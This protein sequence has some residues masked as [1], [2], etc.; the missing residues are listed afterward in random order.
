MARSRGAAAA[1]APDRG[2]GMAGLTIN[3]AR[4]PSGETPVQGVPLEPYVLVRRSDNSSCNAEEVPE[5]G[6]GDARFS[7]RFRWYRSVV[8]RGGAVCFFH[9][10]RGRGGIARSA[11]RARGLETLSARAPGAGPR[12]DNPVH[13]VPAQQGRDAQELHVLDRLPA[14]ALGGAQGAARK[15]CAA[16]PRVW[17]CCRLPAS[18]PVAVPAAGARLSSWGARAQLAMARC[19]RTRT[20]SPPTPASRP[21]TPSATAARPG[22]RWVAQGGCCAWLLW[23]SAAQAAEWGPGPQVGK[24]RLYTPCAD[25]VG[26]VLKCEVVAIDSASAFGELGKT[27]SVATARVRPA[28]SPPKRA[29]TP[30]PPPKAVVAAGKF[31]ALTYNLL[32]DLYATVRARR[33]LRPSHQRLAC[34]RAPLLCSLAAGRRLPAVRRCY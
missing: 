15:R 18:V 32:A 27:F 31:T 5:E 3:S 2:S 34:R 20:A 29:L 9:Q 4:I 24:G 17:R 26:S 16:G 12:G 33:R 14:P 28:P 30:L 22:S 10:V 1:P 25:D 13:P 21:A 8:N 23:P 11:A 19:R 6:S 7:L